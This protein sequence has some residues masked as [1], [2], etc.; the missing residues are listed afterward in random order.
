MLLNILLIEDNE[1]DVVMIK[2]L[3]K[4]LGHHVDVVGN[5][6]DA[7]EKMKNYNYNLILLDWQLPQISGLDF[8]KSIKKDILKKDIPVIM[9]SGRNELK[10]IQIA[11]K[12][13]VHDYIVKPVDPLIFTNKISQLTMK[14]KVENWTLSE[15]PLDFEKKSG[16]VLSPLTLTAISEFEFRFVG[17]SL[18]AVNMIYDMSFELLQELEIGQIQLKIAEIIKIGDDSTYKF[19]AFPVGLKEDQLKKIRLVSRTFYTEEK[20]KGKVA[21]V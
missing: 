20:A 6:I 15:L 17:S 11:V 9:M 19:I 16:Y 12:E 4:Q 10:H 7:Q 13:G 8:L 1:S 14:I 21:N 3:V 18:L 2:F 5:A